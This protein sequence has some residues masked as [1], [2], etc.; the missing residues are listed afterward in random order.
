MKDAT[1]LAIFVTLNVLMYV[2][3]FYIAAVRHQKM[4]IYITLLVVQISIALIHIALPQIR[5]G[6]AMG[7]G[8]AMGFRWFIFLGL[9]AIVFLTLAGIFLVRLHSAVVWGVLIAI[10]ILFF[11]GKSLLHY[12]DFTNIYLTLLPVTHEKNLTVRDGIVHNKR[13]KPFT[14]RAKYKGDDPILHKQWNKET[15]SYWDEEQ[16]ALIFTDDYSLKNK[17]IWRLSRYKKGIKEGKEKFYLKYTREKLGM[18]DEEKELIL[19]RFFGYTHYRK[20]VKNGREWVKYPADYER[21]YRKAQYSNGELL[22]EKLTTKNP[23]IGT[24]IDD[25]DYFF[26]D[27]E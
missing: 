1:I 18:F 23:Y 26:I 16:C 9:H 25:S 14:G 3:A 6:D 20:G 12:A 8:M 21:S 5:S 11:G 27:V 24:T 10:P 2:L 15:V 7:R 13:G 4:G 17:E 22:W 19:T